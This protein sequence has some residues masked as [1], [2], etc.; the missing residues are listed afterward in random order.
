LIA[1]GGTVRSSAWGAVLRE[2]GP[3]AWFYA[4]LVGLFLGCVDRETGSILRYPY[5]EPLMD[6]PEGTRMAW[7]LMAEAYIEKV[8]H[9]RQEI[10]ARVKGR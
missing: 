7:M 4:Y 8:M 6:H 9:E 2:I 5:G 10:S 3:R 1:S